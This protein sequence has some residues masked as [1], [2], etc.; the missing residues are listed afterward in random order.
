MTFIESL[1]DKVLK[2]SEVKRVDN[3]STMGFELRL[4]PEDH[5]RQMLRDDF[6]TEFERLES[7]AKERKEFELEKEILLKQVEKERKV[8]E[9]ELKSQADVLEK[10]IRL[11]TDADRKVLM[12][13]AVENTALKEKVKFLEAELETARKTSKTAVDSLAETLKTAFQHQPQVT[14]NNG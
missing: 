10:A 6:A 5:L 9:I 3:F 7:L 14:I 2:N 12:E 1:I 13:V 4:K 11:E 8:M